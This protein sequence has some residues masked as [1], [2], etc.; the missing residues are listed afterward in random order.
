MGI[1]SVEEMLK[2]RSGGIDPQWKR[3]YRRAWRVITDGPHA[4]GALGARLAIPVFFGQNYQLSDTSGAQVEYDQFSFAT[5]IDAQIDPDCNDDSSW[6]VTVD[7]APYDPTQFPENPLNHPIKISWGENRFDQ[8]CFVDRNGNPITNSAGDY[9]DPPLTIDDSRP[10]LRI[11][12]NEPSY[13]PGYATKWKDCLNTGPFFGFNPGYVKMS[14]PLGDLDY[15][16]VCG[17]YYIVT[18]QF[19]IN[20]NGWKKNI[21]DQGLRQIV[22]GKQQ[23]IVDDKG[24]DVTSPAL[25]NGKGAK[26]ATGGNPVTLT[27]NVYQEADFSSLGLDPYGAPGQ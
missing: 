2:A 6:V 1:V 18:Y 14:T 12:R 9:F 4:I 17:Y 24:E 27:F 11:V 10:T 7:Y 5:K 20:P 21:L 3:T 19:E 8:V 16:P 26:L 22:S 25:L 15:S 13:D 23:K